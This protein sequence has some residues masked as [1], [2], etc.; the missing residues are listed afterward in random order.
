MLVICDLV[1]HTARESSKTSTNIAIFTSSNYCGNCGV[2]MVASCN[3]NCQGG[4]RGPEE[5]DIGRHFVNWGIRGSRG[6]LGPALTSANNDVW[7]EGGPRR[8]N[9]Q[10]KISTTNPQSGELT[11][12]DVL[13]K[14]LDKNVNHY[15]IWLE[16]IISMIS[17]WRGRASSIIFMGHCEQWLI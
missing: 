9:L 11:N 5:V 4:E 16:K 17:I 15:I 7:S 13:D 8:I 12:E 10:R 6:N 2:I 3:N 14:T 1:G